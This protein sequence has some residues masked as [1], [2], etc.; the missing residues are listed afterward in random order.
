[1][2]V[3][4]KNKRIKEQLVIR[5]ADGGDT[6]T[7]DVDLDP[8]TIAANLQKSCFDVADLQ[9]AKK[10]EATEENL[11]RSIDALFCIIFGESGRD[12]ILGVYV[13]DRAQALADIAPFVNDVV[14]PRVREASRKRAEAYHRIK[15]RGR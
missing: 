14:I 6:Y 12:T 11:N 2:Y 3:I 7:L 8:S 10:G 4:D 15:H 9:K 1:M 5:C 13:G